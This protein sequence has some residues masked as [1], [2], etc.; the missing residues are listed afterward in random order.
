ME[1]SITLNLIQ[2]VHLTTVLLTG[3]FYGY[4]CSVINGLGNLQDTT[5]LQSFQS[6]NKSIQNPYF[7]V[8]FIGSLFML[9]LSTWLSYKNC[10]P[11]TFYLLLSATLIYTIAVFGVTIFGNVPLNEQL[12]KFAIST[13]TTNEIAAMRKA[14]EKPWN[15]YHNIRT[16]ASIISFSLAILSLVNQKV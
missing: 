3:L 12:A 11:A 8:S 1:N 4:S 2:A 6:I 14:F 13:A 16:I 9:P 5:Y 10:N 7:F 15:L